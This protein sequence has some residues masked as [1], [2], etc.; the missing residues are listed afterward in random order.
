MSGNYSDSEDEDYGDFQTTNVTL[1][2]AVTE[3]TSDKISHLGGEP[4]WIKLTSPLDTR[5]AKCLSCNSLMN[6]LLQLDGEVPE[7]PHQRIFYVFACAQKKCRR[8][9]GGVRAIRGVGIRKAA[10]A[11]EEELKK[12]R[13]EE[14][15]AAKKKKEEEASRPLPGDMLFGSGLGNAGAKSTNPFSMGGGAAAV[16]GVNP[17]GNPFSTN[18]AATTI[19]A[20]PSS[21]PTTSSTP[22]TTTSSTLHTTFAAALNLSPSPP[23]PKDPE[24]LFY[25]PPEPWPNPHPTPPFPHYFLDAGYEELSAT[26]ESL[27]QR[28]SQ[29]VHTDPTTLLDSSSSGGGSSDDWGGYEKSSLDTTFQKFADR[30]SENPDQVLRYE[31]KGVPLL[32]SKTDAVGKLLSPLNS[33]GEALKNVPRCSG[34][35]KQRFFEFQL[36]PHAIAMLEAEDVGLDGMEWG[37]I[38]VAS[39]TCVPRQVDG[40]GSGV[41]YVEEWVGVQWEQQKK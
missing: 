3:A 10:L 25:G 36:M 27:L 22:I 20:P 9:Q 30:T 31:H 16:G 17:F 13:L 38:I 39:C 29:N 24:P 15:E 18:P 11:K 23:L 14:E 5:L 33:T 32:Y 7:S 40:N 26:P 12:K 19:Q 4:T 6:L 28:T 37:T 1:G 41:G 35:G 2:F 34:C 8:K 21:K